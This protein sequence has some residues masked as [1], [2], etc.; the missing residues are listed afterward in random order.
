MSP[1]TSRQART[2]AKLLHDTGSASASVITARML[3]FANPA[4]A[5]SSWH[6]AEAKRMTSEKVAAGSA[7][8]LAASMEMAM[9]PARMLQLAAR[10]SSWTPHGWM[11]AWMDGASLWVGVGNAAL[12]PA[13]TTVMRNRA[14]LQHRNGG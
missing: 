13:K 2:A 14:R 7:G 3:A 9:L 12:A 1:S 10:P 6:Q 11:Q 5:L 8:L 4:T